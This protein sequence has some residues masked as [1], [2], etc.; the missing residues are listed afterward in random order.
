MRQY[1]RQNCTPNNTKLLFPPIYSEG[2]STSRV[3]LQV[4]N[5]SRTYTPIALKA[6]LKSRP[7]ILCSVYRQFTIGEPFA[8][9]YL[10]SG[11]HHRCPSFGH[12]LVEVHDVIVRHLGE[13][14]GGQ[15]F[16]PEG[17]VSFPLRALVVVVAMKEGVQPLRGIRIRP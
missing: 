8:C 14:F 9:C 15:R 4:C 7:F 16:Q 11:G 12:A 6:A 13:L 2:T 5:E 3:R 10:G 17:L 1:G